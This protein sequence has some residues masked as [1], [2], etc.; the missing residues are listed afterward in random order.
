[1]Q[2]KLAESLK[3]KYNPVAIIWS[4]EM[5]D[6]V[7]QF[8]PGKW[9]CVMSLFAQAAIGATAVFDRD[10]Y[11]CM[12][13][14]TGLGFG[15]RYPQSPE[16]FEDFCYF[17]STGKGGDEKDIKI[18][19]EVR[20][21]SIRYY[22][23]GEGYIKS[24]ELAGKFI[25]QLPII[26]IQAKYV[27]FK[28]LPEVSDDAEEPKVVIFTADPDQLSAL[29]VLANYARDTN[30]NVYSPFGAG[31]QSIGILAYKEI[32]AEN[33]RAVIGMNDISSR[34]YTKRIFGHNCLTFTVP[35]K[36]YLEMESNV[37]GSF[38]E[39]EAWKK[40]MDGRD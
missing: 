16:G 22:V 11:G 40:L 27:I 29:T 4:D 34:N 2:S 39:R 31:C 1:M 13:G 6:D 15:N 14:G 35:Y 37:E 20:R 5:P 32:D 36:M 28:P 25:R 24:P 21:R 8:K 19:R 9:G 30:D 18:E 10:T 12:G 3:L 17:L 33:P 38:L 26:D 7:K 23:E